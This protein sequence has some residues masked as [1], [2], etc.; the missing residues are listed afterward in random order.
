MRISKSIVL[1]RDS[2]LRLELIAQAENLLNHANF[3]SVQNIFPNSAVI[4]PITGLTTSAVV[5]TPEG[6]VNLL[7]GPYNSRGFR[8]NGPSQLS[9]P[10]AFESAAPPRQIS[11]GMQL[12]F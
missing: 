10:L 4:D 12:S 7:N 8:P 1:K 11:F 3:T 5:S 2:S 9:E 6:N